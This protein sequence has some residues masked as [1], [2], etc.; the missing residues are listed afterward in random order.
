M[1]SNCDMDGN[2]LHTGTHWSFYA[3]YTHRRSRWGFRRSDWILASQTIRKRI[4]LFNI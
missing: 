2:I 4:R 1:P 3:T